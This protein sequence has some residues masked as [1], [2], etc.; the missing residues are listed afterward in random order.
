M[1]L[2]A[3]W[4]LRYICKCTKL[5]PSKPAVDKYSPLN[6]NKHA[7][8]SSVTA[9]VTEETA[10]AEANAMRMRANLAARKTRNVNR[11]AD[12]EVGLLMHEYFTIRT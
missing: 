2:R 7:Q 6:F 3:N 9:V 8:D 1:L 10:D 5:Q 4:R 11:L 12:A